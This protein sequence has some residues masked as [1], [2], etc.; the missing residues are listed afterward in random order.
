MG[1]TKQLHV[2]FPSC[3]EQSVLLMSKWR[4]QVRVVPPQNASR[5]FW[6]QYYSL[7]QYIPFDTFGTKS[8]RQGVPAEG[9]PRSEHVHV[10]SRLTR[11]N[12]GSFPVPED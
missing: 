12:V 8:S 9:S 5:Q 2:F 10:R 7:I 11:S 3:A 4:E 1:A 6:L